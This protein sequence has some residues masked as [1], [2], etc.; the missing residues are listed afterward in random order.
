MLL[1]LVFKHLGLDEK[2]YFGL[3]FTDE[4]SNP[5]SVVLL[6]FYCKTKYLSNSNLI[7]DTLLSYIVNLLRIALVGSS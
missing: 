6:D 4:K 7:Y 5:V 1:N 3:L 2:D